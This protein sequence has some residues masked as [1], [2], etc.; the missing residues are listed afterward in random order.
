MVSICNTAPKDDMLDSFPQTHS[1]RQ[2][3]KEEHGEHCSRVRTQWGARLGHGAVRVLQ[4]QE[5][6]G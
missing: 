6:G 5:R 4:E 3:C 2:V 1:L